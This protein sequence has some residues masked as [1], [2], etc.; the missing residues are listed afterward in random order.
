MIVMKNLKVILKNEL[1]QI[2]YCIISKEKDQKEE[3]EK[4]LSVQKGYGFSVE[5]YED[6]IQLKDY[7][8]GETRASFEIISKEDTS[9]EVRYYFTKIEG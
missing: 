4:V 6:C 5:C 1:N 2:V 9:E 8:A 3:F 7:F